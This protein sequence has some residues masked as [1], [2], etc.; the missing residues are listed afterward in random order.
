MKSSTAH[1]T[2]VSVKK[3]DVYFYFDN[4]NKYCTATWSKRSWVT[5]TF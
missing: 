3:S 2:C 5:Q 4:Y 1:L